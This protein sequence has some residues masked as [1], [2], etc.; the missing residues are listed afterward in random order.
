M[1]KNTLLG[2]ILMGMVLFGFM[3]FTEG[4]KQNRDAL[5]EETAQAQAEKAEKEQSLRIDTITAAEAAAV[6]AIMRQIGTERA[7]SLAPAEYRYRTDKVNLLYD[8][9]AVTGTVQAVDTVLTYAAVAGAQFGDDLSPANRRA[10]IENLR[11]ALADADRYRGF[12]RYLSGEDRTV[13]LKND[14]LEL[15]L[16]HI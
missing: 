15:S 13:T 9:A 3:M 2:M 7:D 11:S 12:A 8:G 5:V 1:D 4:N 10:A 14:L 16:I 6:P